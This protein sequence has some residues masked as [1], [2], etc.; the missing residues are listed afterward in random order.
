ML[1]TRPHLVPRLRKQELCLL[2]P[3]APSWRVAGQLCFVFF[4]LFFST[5]CE[6]ASTL[7]FSL[8][9]PCPD[10]LCGSPSILRV[11]VK[12]PQCEVNQSSPS[13]VNV[14]HFT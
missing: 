6:R 7:H 13:G 14:W 11:E 1:T 10:Q 8:S 12:W 3:Q 2:S 9:L 4:Y 5:N